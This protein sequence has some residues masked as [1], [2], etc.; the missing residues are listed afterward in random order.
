MSKTKT[1]RRPCALLLGGQDGPV[2]AGSEAFGG[3]PGIVSALFRSCPPDA[4]PYLA[5][6]LAFPLAPGNEDAGFGMVHAGKH[7]SER[8]LD[9]G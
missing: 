6:T 1:D 5:I 7:S 2:I 8:Q 3:P 4:N 9:A